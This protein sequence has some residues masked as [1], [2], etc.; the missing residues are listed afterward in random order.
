MTPALT[1]GEWAAV[2]EG[3]GFIYR[4]DDNLVMEL[5]PTS[6]FPARTHEL[7]LFR[8]GG[9]S[10]NPSAGTLRALIAWANEAL[11]RL[12]EPCFTREMVNLLRDTAVEFTDADEMPHAELCGVA[13]LIESILPPR[14]YGRDAA[15]V[16]P[17]APTAFK[18]S[19]RQVAI[20]ALIADGESTKQIAAVMHLSPNTV[21]VYL[22]RARDRIV[23]AHPTEIRDGSPRAVI[24]RWYRYADNKAFEA[25]DVQAA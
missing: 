1:D 12:G 14:E 4:P 7:D 23:R 22:S 9:S 17:D 10:F 24:L 8:S 3:G 11:R 6:G 25:K 18:L 2:R 20:C 21:K 16:N 15:H 13:D 5:G 19:P